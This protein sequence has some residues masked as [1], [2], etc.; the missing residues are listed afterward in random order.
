MILKNRLLLS[1]KFIMKSP[2]QSLLLFLTI[3]LSISSQLFII[4]LS[5]SLNTLA[6]SL[7]ISNNQHI[8]IHTTVAAN[9]IDTNYIDAIKKIEN[10]KYVSGSTSGSVLVFKDNVEVYPMRVNYIQ[11]DMLNI[12][13]TKEHLSSNS[14]QTLD[15]KSIIISKYYANDFNINIG[16]YID[17][18]GEVDKTK[19]Y[20]VTGIYEP[21]SYMPENK[22][23]SY[24]QLDRTRYSQIFITVNDLDKVDDTIEEIKSLLANKNLNYY[25]YYARYQTQVLLKDAQVLSLI[26]IQSFIT[27]AIILV[28]SSIFNYFVSSKTKQFGILKGLGYS[29]K[30]LSKMLYTTTFII[31]SLS[32]FVSIFVSNI[33][34]G[35]F[36][37]ILTHDDG[38]P[39]LKIKINIYIYIFSLVLV[40]LA[41]LL[42][43]H[44]TIR[45]TKKL[46]VYELIRSK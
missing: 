1:T 21:P 16:D 15:N 35:I 37:R 6:D 33:S 28:T 17:V 29:Q 14:N 22:Y 40:M 13:N 5:S 23:F 44:I 24:I 46:S 38:T 27:V 20:L 34:L 11:E 45:K 39:R 31:S 32:I 12:L 26:I 42:S 2:L 9:G 10:I 3:T 4:S 25:P 19:K 43:T 7:T 8:Y 30:E 18:G 41:V 36:Q